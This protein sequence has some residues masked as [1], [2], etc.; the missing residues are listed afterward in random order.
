MFKYI[1]K[2]LIL[3]LVTLFIIVTITFFMMQIM[4]GTPFNNPKLSPEAIANLNKTYGLDK[5]VWQQYLQ[6]LNNVAH[7]DF[8]Q[9]FTYKGQS[10]TQLIS[11]RLPVSAQLGFQALV[12]GT[13]LGI[14]TGMWA[15]R[16][17]NTW[18][19]TAIGVFD[20]LGLAMPSFIFGML[21]LYQFGYK[22]QVLPVA[23]WGDSF[24]ETILPTLALAI[25]VNSITSRF[26]R[27]EM[28]EALNSDYVQLARAKGLSDSEVANK[29]AL[30]NSLIPVLTLIG[31]MAANLMTGSVLIE[32]IFSIPGIGAQFVNSVPSKDFPVI[33]G[34]TIV[35][36]VMLMV[37]ILI[38]DILTAIVDPRVRLS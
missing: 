36:S 33:M 11:Q 5:P 8:G 30:R 19:D 3:L 37:I 32:T 4:P 16:K 34:T 10:V 12:V 1:G 13:G 27:T 23:G 26:L 29:H 35:Y 38:T 6:Y 7:L 15:A 28:V 9:S 22:W 24:S 18:I 21:L 17:K 2:R 20:S 14:F 25:G 31:P